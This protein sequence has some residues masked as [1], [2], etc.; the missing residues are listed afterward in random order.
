MPI[1]HLRVDQDRRLRTDTAGGLGGVPQNGADTD[2]LELA[3][4]LARMSGHRY[5]VGDVSLGIHP[6]PR[7]PGDLARQALS[8]GVPAQR[9]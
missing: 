8:C 7:A 2:D 5:R 9:L 3:G 6:A 4:V 1:P